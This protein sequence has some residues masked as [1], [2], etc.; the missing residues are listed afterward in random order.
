MSQVTVKGTLI[1]TRQE[2]LD[3][4]RNYNVSTYGSN[5]EFYEYIDGHNVY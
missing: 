1:A 5:I 2:L 4:F 3:A